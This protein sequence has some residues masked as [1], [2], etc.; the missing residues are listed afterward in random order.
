[1]NCVY[2][3][4]KSRNTPDYVRPMEDT[5]HFDP[6]SYLN[7]SDNNSIEMIII[8]HSAPGNFDKRMGNR[9]TWMTFSEKY[10]IVFLK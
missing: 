5:V 4:D 7:I 8:Q 9:M 3:T 10:D 2:L 1:M 6:L